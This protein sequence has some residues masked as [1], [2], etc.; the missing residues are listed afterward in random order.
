MYMYTLTTHRLRERER[1]RESPTH[2]N[3]YK[4]VAMWTEKVLKTR[5][6]KIKIKQIVK[7]GTC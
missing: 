4:A 7:N 2:N 3:R 1:E 6:I 5:K